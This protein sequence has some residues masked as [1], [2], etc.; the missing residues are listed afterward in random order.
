MQ[1][2]RTPR[3]RGGLGNRTINYNRTTTKSWLP[4]LRLPKQNPR[5]KAAP[6]RSSPAVGSLG[7]RL[8]SPPRR[9]AAAER[10]CR[11]HRTG[12]TA[13]ESGPQDSG[14][15]AQGARRESRPSRNGLHP[16]NVTPGS[17]C[18]DRRPGPGSAALGPRGGTGEGG[19]A[20]EGTAGTRDE[21]PAGPQPG[22]G[23]VGAGSAHR[24]AVAQEHARA[25]RQCAHSP[26]PRGSAGW[27]LPAKQKIAG[28]IP[29]QDDPQ[30]AQEEAVGVPSPSKQ[31]AARVGRL[32]STQ[33]RGRRGAGTQQPRVTKAQHVSC[34]AVTHSRLEP[35]VAA[36]DWAHRS[37]CCTRRRMGPWPPQ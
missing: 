17:G 22:T 26:D 4:R 14:C 36:A 20:A 7:R 29:R 12:R 30:G 3:S 19:A 1:S 13:R 16:H 21:T 32:R 15:S 18:C 37:S 35:A 6:G 23:G 11:R 31:G 25:L 33:R 8:S 24:A 27:A 5:G 9:M 34:A 10:W 2:P 28:S